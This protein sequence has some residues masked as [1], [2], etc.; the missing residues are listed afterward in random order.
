MQIKKI[1]H[2]RFQWIYGAF[3]RPDFHKVFNET[4]G[5]VRVLKYTAE[6]SKLLVELSDYLAERK[7]KAR[8]S[9]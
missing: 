6:P 3:Y 8:P 2:T 7:S 9:V 4:L 5:R 1:N